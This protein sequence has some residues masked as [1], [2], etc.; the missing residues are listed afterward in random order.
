MTFRDKLFLYFNNR[1]TAIENDYAELVSQMRYRAKDE[2]DYLE[3]I[4]AKVRKD[5]FNEIL[6]DIFSILKLSGK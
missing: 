3:L 5:T 1:G 6:G 2:V 4:I